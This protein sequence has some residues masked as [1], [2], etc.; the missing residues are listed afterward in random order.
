VRLRISSDTNSGDRSSAI[1]ECARKSKE[2]PR[3]K[4]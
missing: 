1:M 3:G 2:P 4:V